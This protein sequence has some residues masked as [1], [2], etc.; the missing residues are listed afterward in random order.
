[1]GRKK[2]SWGRLAAHLFAVVLGLV[3]IL[4]I[5][6]TFLVAV[7]PNRSQVFDITKWFE[8]PFT[9]ENFDYVLQNPQ[10]DMPLW[11]L[12]S[13][14]VAAVS[15]LGVVLLSV[16]A[17]YS[18]SRFRY[19]GQTVLFWV[20][21]AGMMIPF[22]S[23]MIP[24]Y[25]FLTRLKMLNTYASLILPALGSSMGVLMLKQFIDGLPES[26]FDAAKIDGC[27]SLTILVRIV[28]PLIRVSISALIIFIFL[29]RWND[30]LWP[31]IAI[32]RQERMTIPTGIV[33]FRSQYF[34]GYGAQMAANA[35]AIAPVILIYL[36]FQKNIVQGIALSGIKE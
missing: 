17:A 35:I 28:V 31:F 34:D 36:F 4:P 12:N 6:W 5:F 15:T 1:M 18:F 33:F 27:N 8:P 20:V 19:P 32:T 11:L 3:W 13:F 2:T 10:A 29:Q 9:L 26:I 7:K 30:F 25:L 21:M 24:E 16:L 22:E 14:F 23:L